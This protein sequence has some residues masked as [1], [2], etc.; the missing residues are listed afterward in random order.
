M[1]TREQAPRWRGSAA[2]LAVAEGELAAA[3]ARAAE[4]VEAN[5]VL[6]ESVER[7]TRALESAVANERNRLARDIHDTSAQALALIVMQLADAQ[8]KLGPAWAS[9]HEPLETARQLA[10]DSLAA[11]RRSVGMLRPATATGLGLPRTLHDVADLMRR[12]FRGQLAV[13][14]TGTP[15]F[16]EPTAEGELLGIVREALTNAAKHSQATRVEVELAFLENGTVRMVVADNGRGFDA[17]QSYPHHYGLIGMHERATRIGA[18][19]TVVTGPGAG[20]EIVAV[21]PT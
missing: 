13:R 12:Y 17:D 16:V 7:L 3:C 14:V 20:T 15:R 2:Q 18:A 19:L 8:D 9:A 21:W 4:L 5:A 10:V 1:T 11:V 6:Q